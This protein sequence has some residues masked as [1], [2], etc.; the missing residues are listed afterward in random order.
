[1]N[2]QCFLLLNILSAQASYLPAQ[3][4]PTVIQERDIVVDHIEPSYHPAYELGAALCGD[5]NRLA[6]SDL[7]QNISVIDLNTKEI[8]CRIKPY[9]I[10]LLDS[11]EFCLNSDGTKLALLHKKDAF[12][13]FM[14]KPNTPLIDLFAPFGGVLVYDLRKSDSY[15]ICEIPNIDYLPPDHVM[16][17][18]KEAQSDEERSLETGADPKAIYNRIPTFRVA[19]APFSFLPN[20]EGIIVPIHTQNA[21]FGSV[22]FPG[23]LGCILSV[24]ENFS[25]QHEIIYGLWTDTIES[26]NYDDG[27]TV[28]TPLPG[29][30]IIALV[31]ANGERIVLMSFEGM[32]ALFDK[33]DQGQFE[34]HK[35]SSGIQHRMDYTGFRYA[36]LSGDGRLIATTSVLSRP[37]FPPNVNRRM[38]WGIAVRDL[39]TDEIVHRIDAGEYE[40]TSLVFSNDHKYLAAGT[41]SGFAYVWDLSNG[42][43]VHKF[44][45]NNTG[46]AGTL[47]GFDTK[48]NQVTVVFLGQR[49]TFANVIRWDLSMNCEVDSYLCPCP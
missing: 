25:K 19:Y 11:L 15:T 12:P 26:I 4:I 6:I 41:L 18:S 34:L 14:R 24:N 23:L 32:R 40:P 44:S 39:D 21:R 5:S 49:N 47:V 1:M 35:I 37:T 17:S 20:G 3:E 16:I 31:S 36:A 30:S 45:A 46:Y 48:S 9:N 10:K 43:L 2:T 8:V 42:D 33:T 38:Q 7:V 28:I 22:Q 13:E 27:R 29:S